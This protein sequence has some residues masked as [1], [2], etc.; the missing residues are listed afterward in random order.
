MI[1]D[2]EI[3]Y[4]LALY[5]TKGIGLQRAKKLIS[6]FGSAYNVF[7]ARKVD[8]IKVAGVG[9]NIAS[10]FP[11][12]STIDFAKKEL[13][14]IKNNNI[15]FIR[16][17][18]DTYPL[19]LRQMYDAPL[20]IMLKGNYHLNAKRFISIV[21]TRSVT[22]YGRSFTEKLIETI[23]P[24]NP[25]IVSGL[26]YGVDI[27]SHRAAIKHNIQTIAVVAHGLNQVYPKK[28]KM[29]A[30]KI[31]DNGAILSEF[32]TDE[33]PEREHFPQRNRII[34]GLSMTT[35]VIEAAKKGGALITAELANDY[36]RDV[37]ALPGRVGE[38]YS[39][40]CNLL[41]KQ[42]KA[43]L[44]NDPSDII[45]YLKWDSMGNKVVQKELFVETTKEEDTVI[46]ALKE[47]ELELDDLAL[48]INIP[49][50]KVV[51]ILLSLEL[52]GLVKPL[53]GKRF[54][55]E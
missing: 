50:Y 21:G 44:L 18:E 15:T 39:E 33:T 51:T 14:Y 47:K 24:Y 34:A 45:E 41:I 32:T 40:G 1:E 11:S 3:I 7:T 28:H 37:F 2:R 43:I 4:T 8:I 25:T 12:N 54:K 29:Y 13:E 36:D 35:I 52:K 48:K 31:Q 6:S 42:N 5:K 23:A 53:P 27:I 19:L 26:A 20:Y 30:D 38:Y 22:E 17:D 16:F 55:L 9:K 10:N 49:V 46:S